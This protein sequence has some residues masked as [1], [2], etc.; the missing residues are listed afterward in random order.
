[1]LHNEIDQQMYFTKKS[2]MLQFHL[3]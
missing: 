2:I 1:M 3:I